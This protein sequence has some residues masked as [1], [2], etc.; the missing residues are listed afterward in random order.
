[1][2]RTTIVRKTGNI[3]FC[4]NTFTKTTVRLT[5]ARYNRNITIT[6]AGLYERLDPAGNGI[7]FHASVRTLTYLQGLYGRFDRLRH[8]LKKCI[9]EPTQFRRGIIRY[10][11]H[12]NRRKKH[13]QLFK[14]LESSP[15]KCRRPPLPG[16]V[17]R[18]HR[19]GY[20]R[21]FGY[22]GDSFE[23]LQL[24]RRKPLKSVHPD[25]SIP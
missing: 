22:V 16:T 5:A 2:H 17:F 19:Q 12:T 6:S 24:L 15:V 8:G 21:F 14:S 7:H 1:M 20:D 13:A 11:F 3:I 23:N 25:M 4:K 9:P 18:I 10:D